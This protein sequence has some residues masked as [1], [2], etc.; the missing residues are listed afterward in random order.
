VPVAE[1]SEDAA[2]RS[3]REEYEEARAGQRRYLER[4]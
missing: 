4:P 3:A 1:V 2:V